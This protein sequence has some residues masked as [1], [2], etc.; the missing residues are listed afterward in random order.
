MNR[1]LSFKIWPY[2]AMYGTNATRCNK[3]CQTMQKQASQQFEKHGFPLIRIAF[4]TL[5]NATRLVDR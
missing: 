5:S 3:T 4:P 2:M 1:Y